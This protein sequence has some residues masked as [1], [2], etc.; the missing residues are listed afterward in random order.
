ML[1]FAADPQDPRVREDLQVVRDRGLREGEPL[2]DFPAA[3]LA[4][5]RDLL[6]HA[7]A[8]G[9]GEGFEDTN[10]LAVVQRRFLDSG[11]SFMYFDASN[12][13]SDAS[14]VSRGWLKGGRAKAKWTGVRQYPRHRRSSWIGLVRFMGSSTSR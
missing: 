8:V 4:G 12:I 7:E 1:S 14:K 5:R 3:Q 13:Y 11:P 6:H 9:V 10:E 2:T